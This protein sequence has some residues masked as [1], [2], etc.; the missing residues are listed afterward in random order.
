MSKAQSLKT[1]EMV[2]VILNSSHICFAFNK[3]VYTGRSPTS[4]HGVEVGAAGREHHFVSLDLLVGHMEHDVAEQAALPHPVHG[5]KGVVVVAFGVVRDAVAIAIQ[6]LHSSLHHGAA[7]RG[8]LLPEPQSRQLYTKTQP[9]L[10]LR[11]C[12]IMNQ[13]KCR[14]VLFCLQKGM[15]G[16]VKNSQLVYHN[17]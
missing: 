2:Q 10:N 12:K 15:V 7:L 14:K 4:K 16:N 3:I 1:T 5:H 13:N 8:L 9:H 6:Q 17:Y 11:L